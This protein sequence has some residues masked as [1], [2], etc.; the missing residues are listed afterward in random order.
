MI[1]IVTRAL[2]RQIEISGIIERSCPARAK[3]FRL[4][5]DISPAEDIVKYRDT[6]MNWWKANTES[7]KSKSKNGPLTSRRRFS[8]KRS[9][10]F[11]TA[12]VELTS[13][14]T[15]PNISSD[16]KR[17]LYQ[18]QKIMSPCAQGGISIAAKQ[19][20]AVHALSSSHLNGGLYQLRRPIKYRRWGDELLPGHIEYCN[21]GKQELFLAYPSIAPPMPLEYR[22]CE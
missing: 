22:K 10:L 5:Y 3:N 16:S 14:P 12:T 15:K 13:E 1:G 19:R 11:S 17:K 9:D 20:D 8:F 6:I 7:L 18:M 21:H 2:D 4:E